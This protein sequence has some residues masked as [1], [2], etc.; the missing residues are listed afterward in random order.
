MPTIEFCSFNDNTALN[1]KPV[2]AKTHI[3]DW[4]KHSKVDENVRNQY[5]QTIRACP[6]MDDWLK[7]GWYVLADRDIPVM[8]GNL[9]EATSSVD[10]EVEKKKWWSSDG[11]NKDPSKTGIPERKGLCSMSHPAD[12][13]LNAVP[14]T[15]ISNEARAAF[16]INMGW[17]IRTPPGYSV[18]YVDPFLWSNKSFTA[19]Q[20]IIDSDTFNTNLDTAQA[21]I[22]PISG[23]SFVIKKGTPIIQVVPFKRETWAAS[24]LHYPKSTL[25]NNLARDLSETENTMLSEDELKITG[26]PR[27]APNQVESYF[28][29][30]AQIAAVNTT[31]KLNG[32]WKPKHKYFMDNSTKDT[33]N[34][35]QLEL[36]I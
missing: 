14:Y 3:P 8:N 21:I 25:Y 19:W 23:K 20:G 35:I 29:N 2:L 16:K 33:S 15:N 34:Q 13:M 17:G 22:Y 10:Y 24:Y 12:Q 18:M 5:T 6:A 31:Y 28:R 32:E 36:D 7:M 1:F 30:S 26:C 4:W 11:T 9:S 27:G